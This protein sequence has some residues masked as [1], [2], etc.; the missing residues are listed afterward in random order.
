MQEDSRSTERL[1]EM[2]GLLGGP[3]RR[4]EVKADFDCRLRQQGWGDASVCGAGCL[5]RCPRGRIKVGSGISN[6]RDTRQRIHLESVR[7]VSENE[8]AVCFK[9]C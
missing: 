4:T 5:Q 3:V 6:E 8:I 1:V 2:C 7:R 9:T